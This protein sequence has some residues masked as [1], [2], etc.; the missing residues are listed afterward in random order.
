MK[1]LSKI[2]LSICLSLV[3]YVIYAYITVTQV[4]SKV[5]QELAYTTDMLIDSQNQY[6]TTMQVVGGLSGVTLMQQFEDIKL[7]LKATKND[8]EALD[9]QK[10]KIEKEAQKTQDQYGVLMQSAE[11]IKDKAR[12][13]M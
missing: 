10:K 7:R 6:D 13:A 11:I 4:N 8:I 12:I 9:I 2:L 3:I 1:T 5:E